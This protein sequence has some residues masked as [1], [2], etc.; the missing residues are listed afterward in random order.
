M[1]S[2]SGDMDQ[3]GTHRHYYIHKCKAEMAIVSIIIIKLVQRGIGEEH[4]PA[5]VSN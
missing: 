2:V 5:C 4:F 3:V 1:H